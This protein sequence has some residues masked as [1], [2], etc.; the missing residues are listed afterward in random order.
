MNRFHKQHWWESDSFRFA[1]LLLFFL[2][3]LTSFS[4]FTKILLKQNN[5][6]KKQNIE[7]ALTHSITQ[8][9]AIEGT[10]PPNLQ[11]LEENYGIMYDAETYQIT[12]VSHGAKRRPEVTITEK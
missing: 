12:Y 1:M 3:I 7:K 9:Y 6:E 2:L 4:A 10:Y 5:A 8:C 11:Y